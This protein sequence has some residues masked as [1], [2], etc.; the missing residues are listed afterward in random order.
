MGSGS[1]HLGQELVSQKDI[2]EIEKVADV[3]SKECLDCASSSADTDGD[4]ARFS[5]LKIDQ[6]TPLFGS[7]MSSKI[8]FVV[9]TSQID[10]A[11]DACNEVTGTVQQRLAH[12]IDQNANKYNG[13]EGDTI[14]CNV[15]ALPKE[16][17]DVEVM[18]GKKND[19]LVLP[20]FLWIKNLRAEE[21]DSRADKLVP[22]LLEN[23]REELLSL[24]YVKEANEDSFVFLCS[25]KTRDK[26]CGITA[27]ILQKTFFK[28][29]QNHDLYRD[30]SDFRPGGCNVT[31]VNHVGGHKFAANV[32]IYL[33]RS[34]SLI[35]LGR[36]VPKDIPVIVNSIIL[37]DR[38]QI[39]WPENVR[40]V[41]KY[42][43]W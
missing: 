16:F 22:L 11:H 15:S 12:W 3:C 43:G 24:D 36:V 2:A 14:R 18:R 27:P 10:W 26:R 29:L 23:K 21:V 7:S 32:I 8:H 30:A 28:E 1:K 31:F 20:H 42:T 35:W 41:Q 19:V 40:C 4:D 34:H 6:E 25:H 9:P 37:P 17:L 39:P 5:K 13:G 33:K 38:P